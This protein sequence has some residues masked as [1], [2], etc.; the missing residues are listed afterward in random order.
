M[1]G[2][3][4]TGEIHPTS[5]IRNQVGVDSSNAEMVPAEGIFLFS[6]IFH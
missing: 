4:E 1:E 6:F 3:A 5:P 2:E